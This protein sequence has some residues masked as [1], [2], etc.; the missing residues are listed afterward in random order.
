MYISY[1][2]NFNISRNEVQFTDDQNIQRFNIFF[3]KWHGGL[4]TPPHVRSRM[5]K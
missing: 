1:I 5:G 4:Q 2:L 3:A